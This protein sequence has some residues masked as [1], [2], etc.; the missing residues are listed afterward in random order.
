[1]IT[2]NCLE[3]LKLSCM[4]RHRN[5]EPE[6][7]NRLG[8]VM[9]YDDDDANNSLAV[10][11]PGSHSDLTGNVNDVCGA[12]TVNENGLI[13]V[14][15]GYLV[16]HQAGDVVDAVGKSMAEVF[17]G[18]FYNVISSLIGIVFKKK[19]RTVVLDCVYRGKTVT[20]TAYGLIGTN[21]KPEG[22]HILCRPTRY[23]MPAIEKI[24]RRHVGISPDDS[25]TSSDEPL[26]PSPP[27]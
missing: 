10:V 21:N 9:V 2:I 11:G 19:T 18:N 25:S 8:V 4:C 13:L 7:E 12:L 23:A 3:N 27:L 16:M 1:M 20:I 17:K 5:R 6:E 22:V 24:L 15:S 26:P 14:I